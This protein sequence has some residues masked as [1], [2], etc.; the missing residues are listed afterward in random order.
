MGKKLVI[1]ASGQIGVELIEMLAHKFGENQ[2]IATDIKPQNTEISGVDFLILDVLDR[3]SLYE[4]I[5]K[6]NITEVYLLAALLSAVSENKIQS[7]WGLNMNGLFNILELA[8]ENHIQRIFWP[9]SIAVF[10]TT[11]PKDQTPQ[12]TIVEPLTVYGIS[13]MAGERWCEYYFKKFGVDVR[14]LRY[15]GIISHK[16][17]PGGG[18]TDYAVDIFHAAIAEK[19]YTCFLEQHVQLPMMFMDDAIRATMELMETQRD[20][21]SV[22]SSYNV[23][24]MNFTPKNIAAEITKHIKEFNISYKPDFRNNIALSWPNSINDDLARKDW[25]W[26]PNFDLSKTTKTMINALMSKNHLN[27]MI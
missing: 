12:S 1:G 5:R 21:L 13:K 11:S 27:T 16:S 2:V 24:A 4:I 9:S 7:A 3:N 25:G 10:G 26:E 8:R 18:T 23:G 6:N 22:N 15:P 20:K 19:K 14:S 17:K